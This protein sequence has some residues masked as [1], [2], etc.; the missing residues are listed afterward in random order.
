M[1]PAT[2]PPPPVSVMHPT[3]PVIPAHHPAAEWRVGGHVSN[4][5][6]G[7]VPGG[8]FSRLRKR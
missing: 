4:F 7:K 1:P 3:G 2:M 6:L 8:C 5:E